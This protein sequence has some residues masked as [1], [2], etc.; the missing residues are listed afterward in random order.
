[1]AALRLALDL[2]LGI[3][4]ELDLKR[5]EDGEVTVT[6]DEAMVLDTA[7]RFY[8][9]ANGTVRIIFTEGEV[10][11]QG[12]E[13]RTGTKRQGDKMQIHDNEKFSLAAKTVDAK[14]FETPDQITWTVDNAD[15]VSL[16]EAPDSKSVVVVAGNPGSAIV[17]VT[18][19]EAGLTATEAVDV[20]AG[21]T[22]L[23]SLTEGAVEPQ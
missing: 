9:W 10:L 2:H 12:D 21:G 19:A 13:H 15:V 4:G 3:D 23:I 18:D 5:G 17:T 14:G 6:H 20:V 16:V 1:M 7:D 11:D 22:A 8:S